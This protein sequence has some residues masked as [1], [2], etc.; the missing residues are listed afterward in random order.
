MQ[1]AVTAV[2]GFLGDRRGIDVADIV[3]PRALKANMAYYTSCL[4]GPA[5]GGSG[6]IAKKRFYRWCRLHIDGGFRIIMVGKS[7]GAHWCL[8][9]ISDLC[10]GNRTDAIL[11]DPSHSLLRAENQTRI[12]MR[13]DDITVV[14]QLGHRSGYQVA[15]AKDIILDAKHTNIERTKE[16]RRI[17]D[18]WL[19]QRNL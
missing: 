1:Y 19:T 12:V 15:G 6:P 11:F 13:P 7:Y 9:V 3:N 10:I 16:G 2:N 8:D 14:R 17:L 5:R 18:E 4:G